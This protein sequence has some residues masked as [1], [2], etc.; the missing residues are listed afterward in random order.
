M[1]ITLV[2]YKLV[3]SKIN[4]FAIMLFIFWLPLKVDFLP[5]ILAFWVLTWLLEGDFRKRFNKFPNKVI[6]F[7]VFFY[8][9][10]T[11]VSLYKTDNI[12]K[13]LFEIQKKLSMLFFPIL[14]IGSN[15]K[16]KKNYKIILATFVIGNL[17]AS[18]YLLTNAF[19]SNLIFENGTWYIEHLHWNSME[20]YSFWQLINM[21]YTNFFGSL[22]SVFIHPSYFSM[23]LLFSILILL[24]FFKHNN[25]KKRYYKILAVF[26]IN[27]FIFIIILLQSRAGII[28][29]L[30]SSVFIILFE[31]LKKRKKRKKRYIFAGLIIMGIGAVILLSNVEMQKVSKQFI[32]LI[33][34]SEN[35]VLKDKDA[36]FQTWFAATEIIKENFW[37]GT[38]SANLDDELTKKYKEYGFDSAYKEKFNAHNQYLESFAGLGIIGFL[39]LMLILILGFVHAYKKRHYLLFFLLLILSINFL[40]ESMMNRMAGILFMMFFYS[41]FVFSF[42][43]NFKKNNSL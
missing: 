40:F 23:Y 42:Q 21:K 4:F 12:D 26:I 38:S 8:F 5:T 39:C 41:L 29:F 11:V 7:S 13:G 32:S 22:L 24:Y 15:E 1:N 6:C 16:V 43:N 20:N 10:L 18:I 31:L 3:I 30:F 17:I 28:A 19:I 14:I 33:K 35:R 2:K 36:R 27:F 9:L 37:F 34:S 25:L